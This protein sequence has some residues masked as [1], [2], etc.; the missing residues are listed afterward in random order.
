MT[1]TTPP[2]TD[3]DVL[4]LLLPVRRLAAARLRDRAA[5]D[6]V[7]QE[8]VAR[9]L[10][11]HGKLESSALLPYA[12]VTARNL[13]AENART[14]DRARRQ[15]HRIIDLTEPVS[16]DTVVIEREEQAALRA[17]LATLPE[18]DRQLLV[19]HAVTDRGTAGLASE[20]GMTAGGVAAQ[21][22]RAEPACVWTTCWRCAGSRC[23]PPGAARCSWPCP[24]PTAGGSG[25]SARA[26][27]S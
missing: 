10:A 14:A 1:R 27:T 18:G 24:R 5:V 26:V 12:L 25:R 19:E 23:P 7:V 17:A 16:P 21:L 22:A 9:V 20:R 15:A 3:E 6:D 4:A 11:A 8:T 13:I 2:T